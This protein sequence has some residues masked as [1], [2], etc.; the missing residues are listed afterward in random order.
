MLLLVGYPDEVAKVI[1]F[2]FSNML[3]CDDAASTQA[4][5]FACKVSMCSITLDSD[6]YELSGT[7]L[8]GAALS[9]S[10][11]LVHAQ[12]LYA[13]EEHITAV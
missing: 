10:G 9:G 8:G 6:V 2:V 4:V 11:V 3:I 5:I 13:V 1:A 7:M 12:E